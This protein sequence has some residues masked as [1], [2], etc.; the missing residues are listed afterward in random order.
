M[1]FAESLGPILTPI[2]A[3]E[4]SSFLRRKLD[5]RTT[6]SPDQLRE[7]VAEYMYLANI[8]TTTDSVIDFLARCGVINFQG[9]T[10]SAAARF[11]LAA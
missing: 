2:T 10:A 3:R 1:F 4:L 8:R 9:P 5:G 11:E 6:A 7:I